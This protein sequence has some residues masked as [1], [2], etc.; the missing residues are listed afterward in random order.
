MPRRSLLDESQVI[1]RDHVLLG[2][3]NATLT[4]AAPGEAPHD[5]T[6]LMSAYGAVNF[7]HRN[8]DIDPAAGMTAD[9]S[10][11]F[12]PPEADTV[13]DWLCERLGLPDHRVLFQIGG[14]FAVSTA[15]ALAARARPGR[16]LAMEGAFHGLGQDTLAVTGIQH[17]IALQAGPGVTAL[18]RHVD[19]LAPGAPAPDWGPYSCL[20][21]EPVQG[22]NGYVP[23]PQ[24]WLRG[25]AEQ[26]RTAGV[27]VIADEVQSGYY[28]HGELSV[29]RSWGLTPDILLFS[30]SM[31]NGVYP[32]SA[33][34]FDSGLGHGAPDPVRLAH[35]FQ[36]GVLGH[37]AAASVTRYLDA[38]PVADLAAG[39]ERLLRATAG[40]LADLDGVRR[41]HVTGPTLS[42]EL[43]RGLSRAVVRR[44]FL[45]GVIAF[46]GGHGGER[47]RVAPPVTTPPGQLADALDTLTEAVSAE[48]TADARPAASI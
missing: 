3:R 20:L 38:T 46:V 13:A 12:Y 16:I 18:A 22:A 45:G 41:V 8:P 32:L 10:G 15:L 33:V 4:L 37:R 7:G 30:K 21:F 24:E 17:D 47:I 23:L 11:C 1:S 48:V 35:T 39:A 40:T 19:F 14:S 36:T 34:V 2:A 26:A 28:R 6:D 29:A 31:T 44:C 9:I 43:P 25:L 27:V 5:Y 42:F